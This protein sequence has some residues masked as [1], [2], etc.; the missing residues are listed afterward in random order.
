MKIKLTFL[1][2]LTFLFLFSGSVYGDDLQDALDAWDRKDYKEAY[3]LL[4]P[5]AE[6]GDAAAQV[7]LGLMYNEGKG[8]PKDYKE[9]VR[10]YRLSVEQGDA[11]GQT[12]MGDM[13]FMG[14]GV[15]QDSKEIDGV[16]EFASNKNLNDNDFSHFD[17][18]GLTPARSSENF[19][20]YKR[21]FCGQ[22]WMR[23]IRP[24]NKKGMTL[25]L[26]SNEVIADTIL[27]ENPNLIEL[28]T[29]GDGKLGSLNSIILFKKNTPL[30]GFNGFYIGL[31]C[32]DITSDGNPELFVD[33]ND[34]G[35]MHTY[36]QYIFSM[37][38]FNLLLDTRASGVT[39]YDGGLHHRMEDLD[40]D[41]VKEYNGWRSSFDLVGVCNACRQP[42]RVIMCLNDN[43]YVDC[44]KEFPELLQQ[45][46]NESRKR[47]RSRTEYFKKNIDELHTEL[48]FQIATSSNLNK[49]EETLDY[50]KTNFS[51]ETVVRIM[52]LLIPGPNG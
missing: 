42:P 31:K 43:E 2:S 50:I 17:V 5:L 9:A 14:H 19:I 23:I 39:W 41:G 18:E 8:V 38:K 6:Q 1:L 3:R 46:I 15:S 4:L 40:E 51:K 33:I 29:Y 44:T 10:W 7:K 36:I 16:F 24:N 35:G 49:E 48:I 47:L 30:I 25:F 20:E 27:A 34:W 13:Y 28:P 26:E 12:R 11:E 32:E 52:K 37:D 45:D 22:Y 21:S